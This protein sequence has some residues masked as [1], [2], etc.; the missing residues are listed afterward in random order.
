M[1]WIVMAVLIIIGLV[2][3]AKRRGAVTLSKD[4]AQ[5]V[6]QLVSKE[7]QEIAKKI[8]DIVDEGALQGKTIPVDNL[9]KETTGMTEQVK[10]E[11]AKFKEELL[12]KY[13][14]TIPVNTVQRLQWELE[15]KGQMWSDKPGCFERHL[16]RRDGSLLFSPERRIV[17]HKE[18][19][20]ARERDGLERQ[21]FAEKARAFASSTLVDIR[22]QEMSMSLDRVGSVLREL[23]ELLEEAASIGGDI[24]YPLEHLKN[25][26]EM[27]LEAIGQV[28]PEGADLLKKAQSQSILKRS[29]YLAQA[30]RKDSPIPPEEEVPALL[31]E[32]L[33]TI[34]FHGFM[35][36]AFAP[37]YRPSE[38]D[39]RSHLEKAVSQGFSKERAAR[40]ITAW[41]E[42]KMR[43]S[44]DSRKEQSL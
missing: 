40:I 11:V 44:E 20:E 25:E 3:Y 22:E 16:Q 23:M 19:E 2:I 9:C 24:A 1:F 18:I 29:P 43:W 4:Q 5:L 13:G 31:C 14:P 30:T 17:T 21:H 28:S 42:G 36:R 8:Q 10:Q 41:D 12:D 39:I 35:S 26:E 6:H 32:D 34:S 38:V 37:G 7:R 27:L 15:G 33:A